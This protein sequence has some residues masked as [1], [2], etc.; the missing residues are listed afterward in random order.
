MGKVSITLNICDEVKTDKYNV[1]VVPIIKCPRGNA[2]EMVARKLD[3]KLRD[4]VMNSRNNL[5]ADSNAASVQRP[6]RI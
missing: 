1:G 3:S 2:A 4:H 5:F 6:G